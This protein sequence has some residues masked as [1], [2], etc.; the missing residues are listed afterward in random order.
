V[1]S[2]RMPLMAEV[3]TADRG[4]TLVRLKAVPGASRDAIAGLLGDRLK[5][6]IS[7]AAEGGKANKAICRL[8]AGATG[9]AVT[10]ETGHG[11]PLK[12][13]RANGVSPDQVAD[14]LD[15]SC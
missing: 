1:A 9:T 4:D 8:L 6:R 15:V 10:I 7:A 2:R 11:S 12:T 14:A 5:V 13:A 3:F